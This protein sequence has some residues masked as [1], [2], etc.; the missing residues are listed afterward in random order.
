MDKNILQGSRVYLSGPMDFVGSRIV[1]KFFGWRFILEPMLST[2][3]ITVLDP[4]N[5]PEVKGM[6]TYGREGIIPSKSDYEKDFWTNK[7]TRARFET[8]FWET[9]HLDLRMCDLSDFLIAFTPT[10]IYRV[11]TMHKIIVGR[12]QMKPTL[13]VSPP[14]TYDLFPEVK[15]LPEETKNFLKHYGLKE[16]PQGLPSQWYGNV[17]GGHYFF[18]GF[19]WENLDLKSPNFYSDLIAN[20]VS[21]S[22][23]NSSNKEE[24]ELWKEVRKWV[25]NND[26][27]QNIKGGI[28]D[29]INTN[30]EEEKFLNEA[31]NDPIEKNRHYFWYN[32]QYAPQRP[33]LYHIFNISSGHIPTRLHITNS[34]DENGNIVQKSFESADDSWVLMNYSS[35]KDT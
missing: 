28:I 6:K 22:E 16:N 1:E 11:G 20:L 35:E 14:V 29:H 26:K 13:L 2:L 15:N 30:P 25:E 32:H 21:I 7:E 24:H 34:I 19:G 3:G 4:W 17:V 9:V 10:N 27:L 12:N 18:D 8:D 31:L 33:L 5:K 23:P